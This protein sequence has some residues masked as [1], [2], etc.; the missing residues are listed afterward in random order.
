MANS[1]WM[2][3]REAA[4]GKKVIAKLALIELMR[5]DLLFASRPNSDEYAHQ[6]SF[7][8][9]SRPSRRLGIVQQS[10]AHTSGRGPKTPNASRG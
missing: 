7:P 2:C 9:L 8:T 1:K 4:A 5:T 3:L 6:E 10:G